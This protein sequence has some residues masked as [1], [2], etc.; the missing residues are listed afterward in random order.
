MT[1]RIACVLVDSEISLL[2]T[3]GLTDC[4]PK[5]GPTSEFVLRTVRAVTIRDSLIAN[6]V[7]NV[8]CSPLI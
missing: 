1:R 2:V 5:K 4:F 8:I 7:V 6:D 3:D